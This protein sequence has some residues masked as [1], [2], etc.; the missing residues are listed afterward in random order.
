MISRARIDKSRTQPTEQFGVIGRILEK[1]HGPFLVGM[2]TLL[3]VFAWSRRFMLDD[4]PIDRA[5]LDE[6]DSSPNARG[7]LDPGAA[8]DAVAD[9]R[10]GVGHEEQRFRHHDR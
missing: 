2:L 10:V 8:N 3:T 6:V 1:H 7:A 9:H 4:R 5:V